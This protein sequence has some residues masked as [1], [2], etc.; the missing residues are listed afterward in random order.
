MSRTHITGDLTRP[1]G[2][3]WG[4]HWQS[5]W[6]TAR[7]VAGAKLLWSQ[8]TPTEQGRVQAVV[9]YEANRHL[10]RTAPSGSASDTKSEENAWDTEI[11]A[12]APSMFPT[13]ANAASWRAKGKEFYMN[14][15]STPADN[16]D[17]TMLDGQTI[18]N[19]V[20]TSNVH[21]DFTIENH[22]A[23]H[24]CYMSCPIHSFAWG[25]YGF[26]SNSQSVPAQLFH[27]ARDVYHV[28]QRTWLDD[29]RFAYLAGKDWPR[30]AYGMYFIMPAL[31][32][33]QNEDNDTTARLYERER[34]RLFEWEQRQSNDGSYFS[35]RFT[36]NVMTGRLLEY[37]TDCEANLGLCYLMHKLHATPAAQS[38][39]AAR[40]A[41]AQ[42]FVSNDIKMCLTRDQNWF[43]SFSWRALSGDSCVSLVVPTGAGDM[44]EWGEDQFLCP[45]QINGATSSN[46]VRTL[47]WCKQSATPQNLGTSAIGMSSY[48]TTGAALVER[49]T[50]YAALTPLHRAVYIDE[51]VATGPVTINSLAS[52]RMFL[53]NDIFNS[54]TRTLRYQGGSRSV[55]GYGGTAQTVGLGSN[56]INVDDRLGIARINPQGTSSSATFSLVD[57]ASRL[58]P[59]SSLCYEYIELDRQATSQIYTAGQQIR[60]SVTVV[61]VESSTQTQQFA[62]S[63]DLATLAT[64]S[65]YVTVALIPGSAGKSY[66]VGA[67]FGTTSYAF[68]WNT[69]A[70]SAIQQSSVSF[71]IPPQ[72]VAIQ[73][74][75]SQQA[76]EVH[77]WSQYAMA[78]SKPL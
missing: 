43:T 76:S 41:V 9:E 48:K 3:H 29:G 78:K 49:R 34:F 14:S 61:G 57:N 23:F 66:F 11:L 30:Y 59:Y 35:K 46:L 51:L 20:Y 60:K 40:Q 36:S 56:W 42:P 18:A 64:S 50:A 45:I 52:S 75:A 69:P 17:N 13:H 77:S 16:T 26:K 55:T 44:A 67:N 68:T 21:D 65:Q 5:A 19:W 54:N 63:T 1:T 15:L 38:M 27:H 74:V 72:S 8:L 28:M 24:S 33:L 25:Y 2:L 31:V 47:L 12:W 62:A 10:T 58:A 22:G 6:W 53:P 39:S 73:E 7:M 37:E 32:M 4:N 70:G 71:V